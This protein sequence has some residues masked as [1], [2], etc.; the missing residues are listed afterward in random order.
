MA[1]PQ[2]IAAIDFWRG[3]V[4][5]VI[6]IDHVPGNA[7]EALTPRNFGLSDSAEAFVFLSGVSV[8][9]AYFQKVSRDGLG[10]IW[11]GCLKRAFYIYRVHIAL[12]FAAI[13]IF[14]LAYWFS[15]FGPLIEVHGRGSIFHEPLQSIPGVLFLTHQLGYFN[16]L[17]LYVVLMLASPLILGMATTSLGLALAAS[18]GCYAL[19]KLAGVTLPTWPQQGEW[20]LDPFAWQL[21]FTLGLACHILWRG[22]S[23]PRSLWVLAAS[24]LVVALGSVVVT[25]AAGAAPGLR[26]AM[27]SLLDVGKQRLGLARLIYFLALAYCISQTPLLARLARS[28]TGSAI[29]RLGRHSLEIFA[30]SSLLSA[31]GQ[32]ILPVAGIT[33]T[34]E[35]VEAIGIVYTLASI[36]GLFLL[37]RV[38]EWRNPMSGGSTRVFSRAMHGYSQSA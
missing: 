4:L 31:L 16:I 25:D 27:F 2:R 38:L 6:M 3:V 9:A 36:G 13:A 24:A 12:T 35:V 5:I 14:G 8:G 21:I 34:S 7:L 18:L 32:S 10:A 1:S 19:T 30:L 37:A 23:P 33:N 11:R 15:G 20:F 26:D 17:P 29:S 28:A 22:E